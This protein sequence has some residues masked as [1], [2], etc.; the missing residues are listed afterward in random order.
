MQC[1]DIER[2]PGPINVKFSKLKM[3]H[4]NVRSLTRAKLKDI[5]ITLAA[6]YDI[7][8]LSETHLSSAVNNDV[9]ALNGFHDII[10]KD[11]P[12]MGGGVAVYIRESI[13][14]KRIVKYE[15]INTEAIWLDVNTTVG[16]L[17]VCCCYRPPNKA[18]GPDPKLF[19]DGIASSLDEAHRDGYKNIVIL[20]D[21]NADL[22]SIPGRSLTNLCNSF[23]F[24]TH[25]NEPTRITSTSATILDQILSNIPNFV[26]KAVILPPIAT[27]D[28]CVVSATLNFNLARESAYER[29]IWEYNK[30]DFKLFKETLLDTNFD[31]CFNS[32]NIDEISQS[33]TDMFLN[34]ARST[35]PNKTI[36]VRPNDAPWYNN[37]LRNLKRKVTRSF[38][39]FKQVKS[40]HNYTSYKSLSKS[41]HR[42]LDTAEFEYNRKISNSLK[43]DRNSKNWWQ[44]ART[45][46]GKGVK[47]IFPPMRIND[48]YESDNKEK[49]EAFNKFF[50]G[51]SNI[52]DSNHTLPL[53][54]QIN[55]L[56]SNITVTEQDVVDQLKCLDTS[57][58]CGPDGV[59]SKLLHEAG[60]VIAPSL[61]KLF[62]LSLHLGK[63]PKLW[64]RANVTPLFK[65]GNKND[66]NNYRPVSL[67]SC[68]SK[69]F[70]KIVFKY[71]YNYILE[72][73]ILSPHQS[74][75]RPKDSTTN[76]LAYMYHMFAQ[77]L[78]KKKDIQIV[79][80]DITKAFDKVWHTG[81][82]FKL[83]K[84]GIG[85][86][87][88]N[89]F[90]DYLNNRMQ[91]V[92]IKNESSEYGNILAGVPQ[93][94]VLGPLLFL[95]YINDLVDNINSNI[96]LFADDTCL[97]IDFE[98]PQDAESLLNNDL[99]TIKEWADTWIVSFSPTKTKTLA[100]TFKKTDFNLDLHF[101]NQKLDSTNTHKHLGLIFNKTLGWSNHVCSL[102]EN[103]KSMAGLLKHLKHV[104]DRKSL[105][106]FYFTFIR[107]KL[108]Y[109]SIVWD[110]C[111]TG[112]SN[113]LEDFQLDIARTVTGAKR[114]TSHTAIYNETGWLKLDERRSLS[115][116]KCFIGMVN[117][118][119]PDYLCSIV[120]PKMGEIR[121]NSRYS[122]NIIPVKCR[123]EF[124]KNTFVPS[125]INMYN[126]LK[127]SERNVANIKEKLKFSTNFLFNYGE[128][129]ANIIC[130]QLRM[131][132]SNLNAHLHLLHVIDSPACACGHD[133][134]DCNHYL[135]HCPL[136]Q[137]MR[138]VMTH[139]IS[140]IVPN[141]DI[142][143][144]SLLY[145]YNECSLEDNM[146]VLQT[147]HKYLMS[148]ARFG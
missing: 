18:G 60:N 146:K 101:G 54:G 2:N 13:L 90:Q 82:L 106:Q 47:T 22:S 148:T 134:E 16:K 75:F 96:K 40:N 130:A 41:Y 44:K 118:T 143:V 63:F 5:Q 112:D 42:E 49:T 127:P 24:T 30:T 91:R 65:K 28:H 20:G 97:F 105:E 142:D 137:T 39:K 128:R 37:K 19:W 32:D 107:P 67:L 122:E 85:G 55:V 71:I 129:W 77:S 133:M 100:C 34:V 46:M 14:Y 95:I 51:H 139:E 144:K 17:L 88:L 89:W 93:G 48:V 45:L 121:P 84:I 103:V 62:N 73:N 68:V 102:L 8:T 113:L 38:N 98:K 11:R 78:D 1:N 120:P 117:G 125:T 15:S 43:Q 9:F 87:L 92:V 138:N 69:I 86:K 36:T 53:L 141:K 119:A 145:G 99:K 25:V 3:C 66:L 114:G 131:E 6:A 115:K 64:K 4:A 76:Q 80:C 27:S 83:K 35:V 136:Y 111:T 61:T 33:W 12:G 50:L 7:I 57:K 56:L 104:V 79:F 108:E 70:E 123:T 81:L 94:S 59:T 23:N 21:L 109:S 140:I 10:R 147:V 72:N 110:N 29:N 58:T 132:C 126:S 26:S 116:L 31:N 74:G 135:L 52:N 124:F